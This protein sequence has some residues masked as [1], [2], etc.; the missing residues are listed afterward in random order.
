MDC[1]AG[2]QH[3]RRSKSFHLILLRIGVQ[4]R[5]YM[6]RYPLIRASNSGVQKFVHLSI[7]S[8]ESTFRSNYP[9]LVILKELV[10]SPLPVVRTFVS[11]RQGQP[12]LI[13]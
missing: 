12:W 13:T 6:R 9:F 8:P 7:R 3:N 4:I 10:M 1:D 2:E 11:F 5:R